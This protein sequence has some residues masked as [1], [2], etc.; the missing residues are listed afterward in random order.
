MAE[1]T[2]DLHGGL[3]MLR[4]RWSVVLL[5]ALLGLG[6]G[7]FYSTRVPVQ[8]SSTALVLL[9]GGAP[10]A[11]DGDAAIQ[12]QVQIVL[13][14]PVL[15]KAGAS[16]TPSLSA[17][18][19]KE[20]VQVGAA[21]SQLIE[22]EAFSPRA[23]QAQALAQAVAV[24]YAELLRDN[25]RS[26]SGAIIGDLRAR[27][28]DLV[29]QNNDVSAQ[30]LKVDDRSAHENPTS[31]EGIKD[32]Q[33][34]AQLTAA[35]TDLVTRLNDV[36]SELAASGAITARA[37][38][39]SIVQPA[40]PATGPGPLPALISWAAAGAFLAAAGAMLLV[41]VRDRRDPRLRARDDMADAV[42]SSVLAD[43]RSR[44][45]RSVAEWSALLETYKASPVDAWA[46]RQILRA[47]ATMADG[48]GRGR[49]GARGRRAWST[50]SR[51]PS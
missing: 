29:Q 9:A 10:S 12:T 28:A 31:T 35:R 7:V 1:R 38:S 43:V 5:A 33:L 17:A 46:F 41:A 45:Q 49:G 24:A 50:P 26:M 37:P 36:K 16:V 20:R 51:S 48:D 4:R 39:A 30:I 11:G 27:Q 21:T 22:I 47:L 18:E 19:V 32:G 23:Q 40:A 3:A 44:P 15:A 42:G 2:T 6:A 34:R 8:L 13:S 25:A 14:T